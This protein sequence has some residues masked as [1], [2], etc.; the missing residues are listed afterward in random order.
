MAPYIGSAKFR[1]FHDLARIM[2]A[3]SFS[4]LIGRSTRS[5]LSDSGPQRGD[6]VP[7]LLRFLAA[8]RLHL[9]SS[10][11][12]IRYSLIRSKIFPRP[13]R[14]EACTDRSRYFRHVVECDFRPEY[15]TFSRLLVRSSLPTSARQMRQVAF[16]SASPGQVSFVVASILTGNIP[17]SRPTRQAF[18]L[19]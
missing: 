6:P 5:R 16:A 8:T 11:I 4:T 7:Y 10:S 17:D 12:V 1:H 15:R 19:L 13:T 14:A 3:A 18:Q 9:A 2:S